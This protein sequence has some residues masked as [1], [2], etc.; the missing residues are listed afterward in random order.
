[1]WMEDDG[2]LSRTTLQVELGKRRCTG[3]PEAPSVEAVSAGPWH[4]SAE[5]CEGLISKLQGRIACQVD[6][7]TM[8]LLSGGLD[9][10]LDGAMEIQGGHRRPFGGRAGPV[11]FTKTLILLAVG[12]HVPL[13]FLFILQEMFI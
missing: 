10:G 1:M 4:F 12:T 13:H 3:P 7:D 2:P 8:D 9:G 11:Q 5:Q 6:A